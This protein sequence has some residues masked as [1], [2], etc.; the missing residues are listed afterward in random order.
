MVRQ[1]LAQR[2]DELEGRLER[3][4]SKFGI[5]PEHP[6]DVDERVVTKPK[7]RAASRV[8]K[9]SSISMPSFNFSQV[10][11]FLGVLGIIIAAISFF[12]YAVANNI[13]GPTGQVGIGIVVGFSLFFLAFVL[14]EKSP[15]W[16]NIV[17][18][19]A[20]F[21]E[22][23]SIGVG[24]LEYGVIPAAVGFVLSFIFMLS[25]IAL[26]YKF[27]SRTI[28]YFS[29]VGGYLI[30]F[31]TNTYQNDFFIMGYYLIISTGLVVLS[32][33]KNW[34]DLRLASFAFMSIY[35][36]STT[37][38][39][40]LGSV[41]TLLYLIGLFALYNVAALIGAI[42]KHEG[43]G[44]L[45]S[46]IIGFLP[47]VFIP[48]MNTVLDLP[49][50]GL[51]LLTMI[52]SFIYLG[53]IALLKIKGQDVAQSIIGTMLSAGF[54]TLNVGL[55]YVLDSVNSDYLLI[56]FAVEWFA[57]TLLSLK[58]EEGQLYRIFSYIFLGLS[59]I[60]ITE[61]GF[62][63]DN[64]AHASVF[65]LTFMAVLA[66]MFYLYKREIDEKFY[67]AITIV[68]GFGLI[69]KFVE[70]LALFVD[71]NEGLAITLSILWLVYTLVLLTRMVTN[72]SRKLVGILLGITLL[73]I[74]FVDLLFLDG[75]FRIVGFMVFGI[76]LLVGGFFI[77][78]ESL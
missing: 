18:G 71:S 73:K 29:L 64:I 65:M 4:E 75:F 43:L 41:S 32:F 16:S 23:L 48:L 17:F 55:L 72:D 38:Y 74:A 2:V 30:P 40:D 1:T 36:A 47:V 60:W 70:Y 56:L 24:V 53:E 12:F 63:A 10:I 7:A 52:F 8:S 57:F 26:S 31:I 61:I 44:I 13:I 34:S 67:G 76:L 59:G 50:Q 9:K 6:Y 15:V 42:R 5:K 45:D 62:R 66:G 14:R 21:I 27:D 20:Y 49:V 37:N 39:S 35:V 25:G 78:N 28:A 68:F 77:K 3:V 69:W 19:G 11:T 51:G 54:I 22:Y 46:L 33:S 58:M